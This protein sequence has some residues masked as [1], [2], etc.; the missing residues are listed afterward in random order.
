M[1]SQSIK[2]EHYDNF[3]LKEV[4][5]DKVDERN[6]ECELTRGQIE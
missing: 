3:C 4:T 1:T 6:D 2:S 5:I